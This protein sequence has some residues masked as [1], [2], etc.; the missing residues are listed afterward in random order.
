MYA[1]LL[2][3]FICPFVMIKPD[4]DDIYRHIIHFLNELK[5]AMFLQREYVLDI[6]N[7]LT[8]NAIKLRSKQKQMALFWL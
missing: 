6:G 2:L 8:N 4:K 3:N 1:M 5:N 7:Y